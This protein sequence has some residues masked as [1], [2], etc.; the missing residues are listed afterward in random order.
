MSKV[1]PVVSKAITSGGS[2]ATYADSVTKMPGH[3]RNGKIK[4]FKEHRGGVEEFSQ[5]KQEWINVGSRK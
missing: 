3:K 4:K 2:I 5:G 1:R